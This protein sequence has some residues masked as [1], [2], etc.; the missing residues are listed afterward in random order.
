MDTTRYNPAAGLPSEEHIVRYTSKY[1]MVLAS[2][3]SFAEE[4]M[5]RHLTGFHQIYGYPTWEKRVPRGTNYRPAIG[6]PSLLKEGTQAVIITK[7]RQA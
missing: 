5:V 2:C 3:L 7:H 6:H 4:Q 1:S